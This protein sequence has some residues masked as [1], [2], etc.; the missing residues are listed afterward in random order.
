MK[1]FIGILFIV[2]LLATSCV[3]RF[4]NMQEHKSYDFSGN[5]FYP[6][7]LVV[8]KITIKDLHNGSDAG[9][10]SY[11][12]YRVRKYNRFESKNFSRLMFYFYDEVGAYQVGDTVVISNLKKFR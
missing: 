4:N 12:K 3:R 11:A 2:V 5:E 9:I 7:V 8:D 10:H 1:K 6:Q